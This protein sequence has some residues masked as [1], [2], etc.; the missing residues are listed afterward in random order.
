MPGW[1][2]SYLRSDVYFIQQASTI[3]RDPN[4]DDQETRYPIC[5]TRPESAQGLKV[6]INGRDDARP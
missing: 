3:L 6:N 5:N 2:M 1:D 4:P